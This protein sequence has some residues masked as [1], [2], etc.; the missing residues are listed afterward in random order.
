MATA[1]YDV[2]SLRPGDYRIAA[3]MLRE[4]GL[5]GG[6]VAVVGY[7]PVLCAYLPRANVTAAADRN[8]D[9]IVIDPVQEQRGDA[10][11]VGEFLGAH[12]SD[13][14]AARADRLRVFTRRG[15]PSGSTARPKTEPLVPCFGGAGIARLT[16]LQQAPQETY[17]LV[18]RGDADVIVSSSGEESRVVA[19]QGGGV[20]EDVNL[21][22]G[23]LYASGWSAARS[24]GAASR[25]VA[26]VNRRFVSETT[27]ST[28]RLDVARQFGKD[29]TRSGFQLNAQLPAEA[30]EGDEADVRVFGI[31]AG[32][33]VELQR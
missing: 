23:G 19:T 3:T 29:A 22:Q 25:V 21:E 9:A 15:P 17:R 26:F 10:F 2:A 12:R 28:D 13:F 32:E 6:N 33:A 5:G 8:T 24:R 30:A 16:L 31:F 7:G 27:P 14:A 4:A 18:R 20:L 11:K 1:V